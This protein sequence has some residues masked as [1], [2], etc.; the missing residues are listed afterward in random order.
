MKPPDHEEGYCSHCNIY[1]ILCGTCGN[2]TCTGGYGTVE[3]ED[4]PDCPSAY[5]LMFVKLDFYL[6]PG[7]L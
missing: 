4:C 6:S 3:G 7:P 1:V 2:K 5:D